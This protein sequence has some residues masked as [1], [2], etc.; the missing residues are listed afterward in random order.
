MSWLQQTGRQ[1][2]STSRDPAFSL[3]EFLGWVPGNSKIL[4]LN[5]GVNAI[6]SG[7]NKLFRRVGSRKII[8]H[9][10]WRRRTQRKPPLSQ[11]FFFSRLLRNSLRSCTLRRLASWPPLIVRAHRILIDAQSFRFAKR[12]KFIIHH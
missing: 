7:S 10:G 12:I 2:I 6:F 1:C 4:R 11:R 9:C 3:S 5:V 8:A